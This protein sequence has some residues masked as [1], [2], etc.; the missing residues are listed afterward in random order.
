MRKSGSARCS[1]SLSA[2]Q[3]GR[4]MFAIRPVVADGEWRL[5]ATFG[6]STLV[7]RFATID[8]HGTDDR[9]SLTFI[10]SAAVDLRIPF[11]RPV[12]SDLVNSALSGQS[13]SAPES[14]TIR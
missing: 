5:S 8:L 4:S 14:R 2:A 3:W 1:P 9:R 13:T 7:P 10:D 12:G 6:R 11:V